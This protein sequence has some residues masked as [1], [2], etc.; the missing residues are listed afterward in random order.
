MPFLV[1]VIAMPAAGLLLGLWLLLR[2]MWFR[3]VRGRL[4]AWA[5]ERPG[6]LGRGLPGLPTM[7]RSP[8]TRRL[9][10]A[11]FWVCAPI[12]MFLLPLGAIITLFAVAMQDWDFALGMLAVAGVG[13]VFT[14]IAWAIRRW[15]ERSD[16]VDAALGDALRWVG[17]S[18]RSV[19]AP[20]SRT[21]AAMWRRRSTIGEIQPLSEP[22]PP[23]SAGR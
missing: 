13:A 23:E 7:E 2:G 5:V 12:G 8:I 1:C 9:L 15:D 21:Y 10:L 6:Q 16:G 4:L 22:E 17:Q 11:A 18:D 19:V 20:Q 14:G 3:A